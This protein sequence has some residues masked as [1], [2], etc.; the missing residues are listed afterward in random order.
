LTGADA[1]LIQAHKRVH[2]SIDY[3]FVGDVDVVNGGF[4]ELLLQ[5]NMTPV[6][7]PVSHTRNGQLLNTNA[8]TIAQEVAKALADRYDVTLIYCFE[9]NGVLKDVEDDHSVIHAMNRETF[10]QLK[11]EGAIFAGM[12]PKLTNSFEALSTG[13]KKVIIGNA[14]NLNRLINGDDGTTITN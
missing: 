3:G 1:N 12:I 5:N 14:N 11:L 4:L 10:H 13:V 8:D 9:K 7:A 2:H 6:I